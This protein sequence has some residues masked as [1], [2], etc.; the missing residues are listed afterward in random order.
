VVLVLVVTMTV[1]GDGRFAA[2][3]RSSFDGV[4]RQGG[5]EDGS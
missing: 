2:R 4:V 1:H 3:S 5:G